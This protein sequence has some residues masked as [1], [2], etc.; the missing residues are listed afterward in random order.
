MGVGG[1][2]RVHLSLSKATAERSSLLG[3]GGRGEG[4]EVGGLVEVRFDWQ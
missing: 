3:G 4:E 2:G 1:L